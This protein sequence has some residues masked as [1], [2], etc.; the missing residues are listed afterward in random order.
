MKEKILSF[1]KT[2]LTGVQESYLAGVADTLS[3]TITEEDKIATSITDGVI[4]TIRVGAMFIQ[5][6]G[7]RR[8]TEAAKTA[9]KNYM[10]K[11]GL[12]EDGKPVK[13]PKKE[14]VTP[15]DTPDWF[16]QY[17][18]KV[19]EVIGGLKS[20][21]DEYEKSKTREAM[22]GRLTSKLKELGV[23]ET[24]IPA[25]TRNLAIESEDKIDQLAAQIHEDYQSIVQKKAEQGVVINVPATPKPGVKEGEALGKSIAAKKNATSTDGVQAKKI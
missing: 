10:D 19:D 17:Q 24:F 5:S 22:S 23:D 6:E 1:L 13:P 8:A 2:K 9:V 21:L 16:K 14:D 11:H 18:T 7:D 20:K 25:M 3:K 15:T 4:E 12:T